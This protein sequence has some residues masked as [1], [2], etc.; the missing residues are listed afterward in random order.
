MMFK[1]AFISVAL[2]AATAHAQPAPDQPAPDQPTP[3][4]PTTDQP[5][6]SGPKVES[7]HPRVKSLIERDFDG[8]LKKLETE[9]VTAA[10]A[11]M[12]LDEPSRAAAEKILLQRSAALDALVKDHLKELAELNAAR[13]ARQRGEANTIL[14]ALLKEA[15]PIFKEGP[16]VDQVAEVLPTEKAT[17]LRMLITEY[18][19]ELVKEMME[20]GGEHGQKK[21]RVQ[22]AMTER[23]TGF[24]QEVKSSYERV[25]GSRR[26][27]FQEVVK[28]LNLSPEQESKVQQVFTDLFQKTYGKPSRAQSAKAAMQAYNMLDSEQRVRF[29]ELFKDRLGN[30]ESPKVRSRERAM[31]EMPKPPAN[32]PTP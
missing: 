11:I 30:V 14:A 4:Q 20:K 29:R 12:E 32:V 8:T 13:R 25:F 19:D 6:L 31:D 5:T 3:D 24:G 21:N 9:P 26:K 18:R 15:G 23:L 2:A 17:E 27:D 10:I 1:H 16:L 28:Q 7:K 22:A